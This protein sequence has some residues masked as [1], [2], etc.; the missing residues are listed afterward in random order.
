MKKTLI[1]ILVVLALVLALGIAGA[2][3]F[4]WYRDNHVFVDGDAYDITL[5]SLDLT[6]EDISVAYYE[7]LKAKLPAFCISLSVLKEK[8]KKYFPFI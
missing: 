1:T 5:R 4:I 2:V 3:G 7:E 8:Y 6:G